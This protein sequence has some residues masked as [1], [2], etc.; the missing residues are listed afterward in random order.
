MAARPEDAVGVDRPLARLK[1]E[2]CDNHRGQSH[3]QLALEPPGAAAEQTKHIVTFRMKIERM[4]TKL[5]LSQN[6]DLEDRQ[7]VIARLEASDAQDSQATARWMKR[8]LP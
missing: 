3:H 2:A 6:R 8:V 1:R 4:E 5:K 7:R